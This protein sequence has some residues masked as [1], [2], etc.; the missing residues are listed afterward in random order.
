[1]VI[2][3]E[4]SVCAAPGIEEKDNTVKR[5]RRTDRNRLIA[6]MVVSFHRGFWNECVK[7]LYHET[8]GMSREGERKQKTTTFVVVFVVKARASGA[9]VWL[10]TQKNAKSTI[11]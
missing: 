3:F 6:F 10:K 2:S 9:C 5:I 1:M 4:A 7:I 11:G 8:E